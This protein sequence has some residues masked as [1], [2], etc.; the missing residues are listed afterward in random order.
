MNRCKVLLLVAVVGGLWG[1]AFGQEGKVDSLEEAL[2]SAQDDSLKAKLLDDLAWAYIYENPIQARIYADS[3]Y[4]LFKNNQD[5][6]GAS[7][8]LNTVA[9]TF[10]MEGKM[11]SALNLYNQALVL[12]KP[13][14]SP[15]QIGTLYNNI[16]IA[17]FNAGRIDTAIVLYRK[18]LEYRKRSKD[19]SQIIA[20]YI[21]LG[22]ALHE[23]G[24][25]EQ[26]VKALILA[27][28]LSQRVNDAESLAT[29]YANLNTAHIDL[30]EWEQ[31]LHYG[32][33]AQQYFEAKNNKYRLATLYGNFGA[34]FNHL[35]KPDSALFYLKKALNI[36][37]FDP[38]TMAYTLHNLG[39]TQLFED[40][41]S[42]ALNYYIQ[43]MELEQELGM[44]REL[45]NSKVSVGNILGKMGRYRQAQPYLKDAISATDTLKGMWEDRSKALKFLLLTE[46]HLKENEE[47]SKLINAYSEAT[48]SLYSRSK[49]EAITEIETKYQTQQKEL[50]N[51]ALQRENELQATI[52]RN[53]RRGIG[54]LSLGLIALAGLSAFLYRQRQRIQAQKS[55][56]ELLHR[57]QRHRMMNNLVF[58]NSLMSLQVNRLKEQPEAQQALREAES[59]LRA[60][61]ALHNRLHHDGEGQKSIL[62]HD[63]LDEVTTALQRS[64]SSPESPVE[65]QLH[66]PEQEQVDGDAA[67]RIG[68]IVNELATNSCKHAF[69]EQPAPQINIH[70]K[71]EP[72]GRSRLIYTDNGS[73][74]PADFEVD[75]KKS[76]GL[77][78]IHNLVKQLN[79]RISFSG[80]EGTRVECEL[81]LK[82]A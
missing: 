21:N 66:C 80:D 82:A 63:Y 26:G 7:N 81:D 23:G 30:D 73:G 10:L 62:I 71:P 79:G 65:I 74:L 32:R 33:L 6:L 41:D 12:A 76:M 16:G 64:F 11:D 67:M 52:N 61:S 70:L 8:A 46:S 24:D 13:N 3:S 28:D 54:G 39:D 56:I 75:T 40:N 57:E 31:A 27:V 37:D 25:S 2:A 5:E 19:T 60:M 17:H 50:Q 29:S 77:F 43:A 45:I 9:N 49:F 58:A 36:N 18:G 35:G 42:A 44:S 4:K 78:L 38:Y 34:I 55:E 48:D 22:G 69:K 14:G 53:Q 20:S 47:M 1:S 68:L 59:R 15:R 51:Q 72:E